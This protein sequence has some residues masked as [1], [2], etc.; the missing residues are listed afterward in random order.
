MLFE[1]MFWVTSK[2]LHKKK[3]ERCSKKWGQITG[4]WGQHALEEEGA[5][6]VTALRCSP[7]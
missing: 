7:R 2:I 6:K 1:Q 4:L 5:G 3:K